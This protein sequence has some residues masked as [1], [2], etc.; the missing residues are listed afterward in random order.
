MDKNIINFS[1]RDISAIIYLTIFIPMRLYLAYL[2]YEVSKKYFYLLGV[3]IFLIGLL[4][5]Y[6]YKISSDNRIYLLHCLLYLI[7]FILIINKEKIS[8]L[9]LAVDVIISLIYWFY[10]LHFKLK[11]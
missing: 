7:V 11:I 4:Y 9:L 8:G 5:F 2:P 3:L 1:Q 6:L 10:R